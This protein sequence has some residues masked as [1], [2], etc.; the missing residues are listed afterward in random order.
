[1]DFQTRTHAMRGVESRMQVA[2]LMI[3]KGFPWYEALMW[4]GVNYNFICVADGYIDDPYSHI[5][6]LRREHDGSIKK[7]Q[8]I[9]TCWYLTTAHL[10][11]YLSE[12]ETAVPNRKARLIIGKPRGY[13][14]AAFDCSYC[15]NHYAGKVKGELQ[16]DKKAGFGICCL[17]AKSPDYKV[18]TSTTY[19][20]ESCHNPNAPFRLRDW[21]IEFKL[22]SEDDMRS[23]AYAFGFQNK[24]V[25]KLIFGPKRYRYIKKSGYE[26]T[27]VIHDRP[28]KCL[29]PTDKTQPG[30]IYRQQ[31]IDRITNNDSEIN[32]NQDHEKSEQ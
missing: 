9:S 10:D 31:I 28:V 18:L 7:V 12:V 26:I 11:Q 15:G 14:K 17:C 16:Y 19:I 32:K 1:M 22:L 21:K 13:H 30:N 25:D 6:V 3:D 2:Q 20:L 27:K 4:K 24:S 5:E 29:S 8:R 23:I